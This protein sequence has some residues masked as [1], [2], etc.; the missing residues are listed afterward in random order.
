MAPHLLPSAGQGKRGRL[1]VVA[2]NDGL[3]VIVS[4]LPL[5]EDRLVGVHAPGIF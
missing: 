2:A 3:I 4:L 5:G 1:L